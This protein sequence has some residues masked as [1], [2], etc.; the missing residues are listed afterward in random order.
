MAKAKRLL[1]LAYTEPIFKDLKLLKVTDILKIQELKFNY[2]YHHKT[3]A[4]H[5]LT[6]MPFQTNADTHNYNTRQHRQIHQP[7]AKHEYA[8]KCIRF[9]IPKLINNTPA[10][11]LDKV[12]THSLQGFS[13]Y[14]KQYIL[15]KY[16][17]TCT[18]DN[19]YICSRA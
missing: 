1:S 10:I 12:W 15:D 9:D 13:W 6:N 14:I 5:L 19:C 3:L 8:K 7:T 11:I 18:I 17:N 2:K 16:E 4:N